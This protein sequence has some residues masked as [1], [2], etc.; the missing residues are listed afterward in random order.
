LSAVGAAGAAL[1][2]LPEQAAKA[3]AI[4]AI[5]SNFFIVVVLNII[6]LKNTAKAAAITI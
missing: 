5:A 1:L 2:S 6:D 3:A 4:A